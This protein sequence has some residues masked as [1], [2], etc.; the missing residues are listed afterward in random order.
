MLYDTSVHV[1]F[2]LWALAVVCLSW[3]LEEILVNVDGGYKLA[4]MY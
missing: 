2:I 3:S 1:F 4:D